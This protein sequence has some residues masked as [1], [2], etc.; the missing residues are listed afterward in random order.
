M[1]LIPR[2]EMNITFTYM[3]LLQS[4][5]SWGGGTHHHHLHHLLDLMVQ[6]C[7]GPPY[8]DQYQQSEHI[9][10]KGQTSNQFSS[11]A[12]RFV[13]CNARSEIV[14]S[15]WMFLQDI[16]ANKNKKNYIKLWWKYFP[17]HLNESSVDPRLQS[18]P[19]PREIIKMKS[20]CFSE[21]SD[22]KMQTSF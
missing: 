3:F 5:L 18:W 1:Y 13:W 20:Y 17:S 9:T 8:A 15:P 14:S 22:D 7:Y 21:Y 12:L 11:R 16:C 2:L 4:V 6:L 10:W 19:V